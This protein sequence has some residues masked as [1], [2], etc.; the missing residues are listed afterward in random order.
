[1]AYQANVVPVGDNKI[2]RR[3]TPLYRTILLVVLG[4]GLS[5][6]MCFYLAHPKNYKFGYPCSLE[7]RVV[8]KSVALPW[9]MLTPSLYRDAL[10]ISFL[11]MSIAVG[12]S[13]PALCFSIGVGV[14]VICRFP[15]QGFGFCGALMLS[16]G[17]WSSLS[18]LLGGE[19]YSL[20]CIWVVVLW[21]WGS[22]GCNGRFG[23]VGD[24]FSN[25]MS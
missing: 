4:T 6:R 13:P 7:V 23:Y 20:P 11:T 16:P 10:A 2:N 18:G 17:G 12:G 24:L 14:W 3:G 21:Y 15:I 9:I 25:A 22:M 5:A 8:I 19:K 1:V